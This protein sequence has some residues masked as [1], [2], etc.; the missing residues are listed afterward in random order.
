MVAYGDGGGSI[1]LFPTGGKGVASPPRD[2]A[3]LD[4]VTEYHR[5]ITCNDI[6]YGYMVDVL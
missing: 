3:F 2:I 1:E 5:I 4:D 6:K